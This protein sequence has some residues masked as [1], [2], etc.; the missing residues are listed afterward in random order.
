[1]RDASHSEHE[2]QPMKR[3]IQVSIILTISGLL[4]LDPA[5]AA[6][7]TPLETSVLRLTQS[8]ERLVT[9]LEAKSAPDARQL[10]ELQLRTV[11]DVLNLRY[12]KIDQLEQEIRALEREED[13]LREQLQRTQTEWG[14]PEPDLAGTEVDPAQ[15]QQIERAVAQET[16]YIQQRID[17]A[18]ERKLLLQNELTGLKRRLVGLEQRLDD[19]IERLP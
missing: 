1:L 16:K 15:R 11:I 12:R 5:A 6:A 10:D 18:S 9:L 13:D 4:R 3:W 7:S 17:R 2:E 19:W 8:V 14:I